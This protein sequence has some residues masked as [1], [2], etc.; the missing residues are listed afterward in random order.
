MFRNNVQPKIVKDVFNA[1]LASDAE[2][3]KTNQ[4]PIIPPEFIYSEFPQKIL[5]FDKA[6]HSKEDLSNT[7]ICTYASD[8]T[9]KRIRQAPKKYLNFFRRS[10]GIIGFDISIHPDMP[11]WKQTAFIGENLELTYFYG[12]NG[13]PVI[14]NIRYGSDDTATELFKALPLNSTL[15]IGTH[16]FIKYKFQKAEWYVEIDKIIRELKPNKLIVYGSLN[17]CLF[18]NFFNRT[19]IKIYKDWFSQ[20]IDEEKNH[21]F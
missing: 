21:V 20:H 18:H 1:Y 10:A 5:P 13:I 8:L 11:L 3:T 7:F 15:A 16:G 19:E 2:L 6:L 4:Y 14:P 12:S 9:F 17:G